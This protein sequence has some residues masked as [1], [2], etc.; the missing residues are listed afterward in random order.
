MSPDKHFY[1]SVDGYWS[2]AVS[3]TKLTK[4]FYNRNCPIKYYTKFSK[5]IN[6][7]YGKFMS[8]D[9]TRNFL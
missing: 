7:V 4:Y 6:C 3:I 9:Y 8:Y 1:Y 5:N 2:D